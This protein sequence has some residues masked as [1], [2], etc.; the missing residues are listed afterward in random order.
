MAVFG[1]PSWS[2]VRGGGSTICTTS[3]VEQPDLN[4]WNPD[5]QDAILDVGALLARPRRRRLPPRRHQLHRPRPALRDNPP[6]DHPRPAGP[7]GQFQRHVHD[8]SQPET[9]AFLGRLRALID[10][11]GARMTLGEIGD[12]KD[13]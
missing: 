8:R 13:L 10:G 5:V 1:G 3:C 9:L 2:W 12:E 4:Y 7:D 11:Y 6:R